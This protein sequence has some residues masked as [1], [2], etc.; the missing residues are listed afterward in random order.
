[1]TKQES[2]RSYMAENHID[3]A[4]ITSME[5]MQWYSG[6]KADTGWVLVT[7]D[8]EYFITDAR[9]FEMAEQQLSGRFILIQKRTGA[10]IEE[11]TEWVGKKNAKLGIEFEKLTIS[12]KEAFEAAYDFTYAPVDDILHDLRAVKTA[13]EIAIMKEGCIITDSIFRYMCKQIKPGVT[14]FDLLAEMNWLTNK[15]ECFPS[16][17][18][19]IASGPNSSSPH[20]VI[21]PR[22]LQYGDLITMDYGVIY[23]GL[24]TDCTRTVALGDIDEELKIIYNIVYNANSATEA[25]IKDGESAVT[26]DAVARNIIRDAGY[27]AYYEHGTGHGVGIEIHEAPWLSTKSTNILRENMVV[28]VEPGIYL[29]G[30]GGVRIED[31]GAVT[32]SGYESFYKTPKELII[33]E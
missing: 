17:D 18:P 33:I 32:K 1:M 30:K 9:Y 31:M 24:H 3:A 14:E 15:Y 16:F 27:G 6:F 26:V 13:E 25:A 21:S 19:I 8:R 2:L 11:I 20:A 4:L 22:K 29:P 7:E 23:K 5:N 28:T 10:P 12:Q